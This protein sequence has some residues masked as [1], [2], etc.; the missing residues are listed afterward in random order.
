MVPE[1]VLLVLNEHP[2]LRFALVGQFMRFYFTEVALVG[3]FMHFCFTE[4]SG[5]KDAKVRLST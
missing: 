4:S 5:F 2:L 1:C 3:H